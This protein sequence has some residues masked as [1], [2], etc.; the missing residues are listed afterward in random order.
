MGCRIYACRS[1]SYSCTFAYVSALSGKNFH[2]KFYFSSSA[3]IT[4]QTAIEDTSGEFGAAIQGRA[5]T[6]F[7]TASL[8]ASTEMTVTGQAS[9]SIANIDCTTVTHLCAHVGPAGSIAPYT[10]FYGS[11]NVKCEVVT[12]K[13][14]CDPGKY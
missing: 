3:D 12:S 2:I 8:T 5:G 7:A 13:T 1:P 14:N 9:L 6:L 11:N 4:G 10:D